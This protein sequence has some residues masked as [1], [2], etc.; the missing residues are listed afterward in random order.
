VSTKSTILEINGQRYDAISGQLLAPLQRSIDGILPADEAP[1]FLFEAASLTPEPVVLEQVVLKPT[2]TDVVR[3]GVNLLSRQTETT[4]TLMRHVVH[5]PEPTFKRQVKVTSG[6][7]AKTTTK[8]KTKRSIPRLDEPR[9]KRAL[10]ASKSHAVKKFSVSH[11]EQ[12]AHA[13]AAAHSPVNHPQI[14]PRQ[15]TPTSDLINKAL[16]H[17]SSHQQ[18]AIKRPR[19]VSR[20]ATLIIGSF[21]AFLLVTGV[22]A[23][24]N[25]S[26]VKMYLASSKAG[27]T[28]S[29][30]HS[31]PDGFHLQN[32]SYTTGS[33]AVNYLSNSD[34]RAYTLTQKVS[35][36]DS[37]TLEENFVKKNAGNYQTVEQAGQNIYLYG[38]HQATWV[39]GGVWYQISSN[40]S[41]S[42]RQLVNL[43]SSL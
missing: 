8:L 38:N 11:T 27:F 32:V 37:A 43:A 9:L 33:V 31:K 23:S 10:A 17:A 26:D 28:A 20:Q 18:P 5:K 30:P 40:G 25:M 39:S 1:Q 29:L 36:W 3:P 7:H 16:R 4:Q 13:I 21:T 34:Q 41:L 15:V 12:H 24:Q 19:R 22:L 14:A 35:N 6:N 42:D 2:M